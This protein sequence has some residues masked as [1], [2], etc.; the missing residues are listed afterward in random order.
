MTEIKKSPEDD[1]KRW[2]DDA[3]FIHDNW[4][5]QNERPVETKAWTQIPITEHFGIRSGED[6]KKIFIDLRT[7]GVHL[8]CIRQGLFMPADN[9]RFL[10][11]I[12]NLKPPEFFIKKYSDIVKPDHI[13]SA[14]DDK[15]TCKCIGTAEAQVP[16]LREEIR[17]EWVEW[18]SKLS[19]TMTDNYVDSVIDQETIFRDLRLHDV[20]V[21]DIKHNIFQHAGN[22]VC[23]YAQQ[24]I[25]IRFWFVK[26]YAEKI[27]KNIT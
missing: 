14:T 5:I 3:R 23:F 18:S 11:K 24:G 13:A 16:L 19:K 25:P 7:R 22:V 26:K 4:C 8:S 6:Q 9:T 21:A 15:V 10:Y 2:L 1:W 17:K 27:G 12:H 20:A